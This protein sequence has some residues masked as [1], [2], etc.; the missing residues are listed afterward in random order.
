MVDTAVDKYKFFELN[1]HL[2]RGES[3][4]I[5][6]L[7]NGFVILNRSMYLL[8]SVMYIHYKYLDYVVL[9]NFL[10]ILGLL[11]WPGPAGCGSMSVS[12]DSN[13]AENAES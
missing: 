8:L 6:L 1:M 12:R 11:I 2:L 4:Y 7:C 3:I 5:S 13:Y 10:M 9:N